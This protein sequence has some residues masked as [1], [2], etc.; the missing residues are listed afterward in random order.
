MTRT[1][2]HPYRDPAVVRELTGALAKAAD[3]LGEL[4][5]MHVCGTHEHELGRHGI[6]QLLP[7]NV[8]LIAG[9]GCPVCITPASVI[10]TAIAIAERDDHPILCTY[11]DM[12]RVPTAGGSI[13]DARGRGADIRI[14]YGIRDAAKLAID[15]P[16]RQVVFFSV[17]FETTAAPVA[18]LLKAGVPDNFSIYCC[19]R[20][21]P[22]AV[23]VLCEQDPDAI[24]GFFLPGHAA[25]ITG[26]GPYRFLPDEFGTAAAIAGFE[27][28][29]ILSGLLSIVRQIR[30]GTPTVANCYTRAVRDNGN[31]NA[32]ALLDEVFRPVDAAWRGIGVLPGTGYVLDDAYAHL[33]ALARFGMTGIEAPD[34]MPGCICHLVLMGRNVPNDCR[35]FGSACTPDNPQGP[36]MVSAEGTC[37]ARFLYPEDIDV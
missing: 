30:N 34:I 27:P 31:P 1:A 29:D 28:V 11:G 7:A 23:R 32:R 36:C 37:R 21:V 10:A 5:I 20:Y 12:V 14:I 9:P 16:D 15:N 25:V 24:D 17:G 6:R 19:H 4:A 2:T 33:D 35:L 18:S 22:A 13:L 8:R 3:G 26:A